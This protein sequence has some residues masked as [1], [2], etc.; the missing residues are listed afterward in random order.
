MKSQEYE[1]EIWS[2][3][4]PQLSKCQKFESVWGRGIKLIKW[5]EFEQ[6]DITRP[7]RV[8][9]PTEW[10]VIITSVVWLRNPGRDAHQLLS[11]NEN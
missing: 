2:T 10:R 6:R 8:L 3:I 4:V 9:L 11:E 7:M 1:T 5:S